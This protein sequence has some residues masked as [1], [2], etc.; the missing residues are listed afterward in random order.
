M[1][2]VFDVPTSTSTYWD[3]DVRN[4]STHLSDFGP[5]PLRYMMCKTK[6]CE[7][8][9]F[10]AK[11]NH[12]CHFVESHRVSNDLRIFRKRCSAYFGIQIE[13]M[14]EGFQLVVILATLLIV[15]TG[16]RLGPPKHADR[17][18]RSSS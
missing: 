18:D 17:V 7:T 6:A 5:M 11:K 14:T 3:L 12:Y 1:S 4:V 15:T 8:G 9:G 13:K 16:D 10:D 2:I